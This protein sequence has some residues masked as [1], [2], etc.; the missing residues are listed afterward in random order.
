MP[1]FPILYSINGILLFISILF[2]YEKI[3]PN[4]LVGIRVGK[5]LWNE[6]NWY[7][8]HTFAGWCM[9]IT[10]ILTIIF[11]LSL[12]LL[13]KYISPEIDI[14]PIVITVSIVGLLIGNALIPSVYSYKMPD[15]S[16]HTEKNIYDRVSFSS[17]FAVAIYGWIS[18]LL[19]IGMLPLAFN[20]VEPNDSYGFRTSK[21]LSSE[22]NWY[23]GNQ[24]S[25]RVTIIACCISIISVLFMKLYLAKKISL[26]NNGI[27]YLMLFLVP[28]AINIIVTVWYHMKL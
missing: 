1:L 19:I 4:D 16:N 25:G 2:I 22:E 17:N 15:S 23:K 10:S 27:V 14:N 5:A 20:R 3:G 13:R 18:F 6:T 12:Q 28:Q 8:V 7:K 26:L 24:F 9:L 11:L 21:T